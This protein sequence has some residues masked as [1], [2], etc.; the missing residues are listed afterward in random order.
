MLSEIE[1][2]SYGDMFETYVYIYTLALQKGHSLHAALCAFSS[3]APLF[4]DKLWKQFVSN[5]FECSQYQIHSFWIHSNLIIKFSSVLI[6]QL[7]ENT[8]LPQCFHAVIE[9]RWQVV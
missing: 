5:F 3:A 1:A 6:T 8:N 4:M 2:L 7:K 9:N